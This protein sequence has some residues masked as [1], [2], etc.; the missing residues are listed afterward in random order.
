MA[1]TKPVGTETLS[2]AGG[3][4]L[5]GLISDVIDGI[6]SSANPG[7]THTLSDGATDVSAT[8]TE[9]NYSSGVTSAIQTQLDAKAEAGANSSITSLSGLTTPL[10]VSQGG[11]GAATLTGIVKGNGT[12]AFTA[13][14]APTGTIVG[15]SDSQTLTNKTLTTPIIDTAI[16]D[17]NGNEMLWLSVTA[18][19]NTELTIKNAAT[20]G[21]PQLYVTSDDVGPIAARIQGKSAF[22]QHVGIADLGTVGAT[23]TVD[24]TNGDRQKMTLD[25]NL[26]I[27]FSNPWEGQTLTLY[28]LQDGS[29]TNTITFSD[30]IVWADNATPSWTTTANKWNIA[31]ITYVGGEYL[32][33]G[34][35]FA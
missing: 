11:S 3:Q 24:W 16:K 1:I 27:T 5:A 32:G 34:N 14:S 26:T 4:G 6:E 21:N 19:A 2:A 7:H 13:V 8:S 33:V 35:K 28:M 18:S 22:N 10:S 15:T 17:T 23:E 20:G 12:S 25:E 9:L 30:T 31:V 29:G